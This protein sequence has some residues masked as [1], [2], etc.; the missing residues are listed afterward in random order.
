[1]AIV[2]IQAGLTVSL[3][4]LAVGAAGPRPP[5]YEPRY[6]PATMPDVTAGGI[7]AGN[8]QRRADPRSG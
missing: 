2:A 6:E 3:P 8:Q 5:G 4:D 7:L 1:M